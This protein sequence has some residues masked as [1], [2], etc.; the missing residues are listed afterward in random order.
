MKSPS[1]LKENIFKEKETN[2]TIKWKE[3]T[4]DPDQNIRALP[5]LYQDIIGLLDEANHSIYNDTVI[6]SISDIAGPSDTIDSSLLKN[7]ME[8]FD[9]FLKKYFKKEASVAIVIDLAP[10][11]DFMK[12]EDPSDFR[13]TGISNYVINRN[14]I[15]KD[16]NSGDLIRPITSKYGPIILLE[17]DDKMEYFSV[18]YLMMLAFKP[19]LIIDTDTEWDQEMRRLCD[20]LESAGFMPINGYCGFEYSEPYIWPNDTG[21]RLCEIISLKSKE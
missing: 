2:I 18:P 20:L 5:F 14:Q 13:A 8:K 10:S 1:F 21:K 9:N 7:A 19:S 6:V 12:E 16:L 3:S 11:F 17:A 15:V 4:I